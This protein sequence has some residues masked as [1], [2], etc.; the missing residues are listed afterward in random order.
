MLAKEGRTFIQAIFAEDAAAKQQ[1]LKGEALGQWRKERIAPLYEE[2]ARWR[3]AVL[4]T[5][6]P[7][8]PLAGV[9]RYYTTHWI[10]LTRWVGDPKLPP[11]N[12]ASE[13]VF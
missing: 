8:E 2:F 10:A 5:L 1:G 3:D 11:D 13:R 7:D 6:L 9:L 4:P 12:S